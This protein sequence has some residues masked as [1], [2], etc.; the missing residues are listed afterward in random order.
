[1]APE[2]TDDQSRRIAS[3]ASKEYDRVIEEFGA[4][5]M[6][7][8]T[9]ARFP[10]PV[11]PL[12]KRRIYRAGRDLERLLEA[13]EGGHRISV[14]TGVGPSGP[15]HLGHLP[16]FA[17]A[18][19]FQE[20]VDAWVYIPVSEDE[21]FWT[22]SLTLD[23]IRDHAAANLRDVL[24]MGFDPDRTRVIIDLDDADILYPAATAFAGELTTSQVTAVYG[25]QENVGAS[26]YPSVQ[27][28]HLLLPQL[29][30]GPHT[31]VVPVGFDQDPHIRV[32]R[33][34]ATKARYPVQ[35]P[36]ALLGQF[37]P[38]LDGPGKMSSSEGEVIPLDADPEAVEASMADAYSGGQA[39]VAAHRELGGDPAVDVAFQ[40]LRYGF[41]PNDR[42]LAALDRAYRRGELLS[43]DLKQRA[44]ERIVARLRTLE[45]HRPTDPIPE[46]LEPYR[47]T[48]RERNAARETLLD[49]PTLGKHG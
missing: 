4:D 48:E 3:E 44:I 6:D 10:D 24:A 40:Y 41:E 37:L 8:E 38:A 16:A 13:I 45:E 32:A 46:V 36:A 29:V 23:D 21:K 35:K 42:R 1:M 39:T 30:H 22:R 47:L 20:V 25:A 17:L 28:A 34:I 27:A 14:V 43:G 2:P 49:P 26:F 19:Y 9:I 33:D 5:R 12:L 7:W 15:M 11:H 18:R 31:T